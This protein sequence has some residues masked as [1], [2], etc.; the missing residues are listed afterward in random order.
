MIIPVTVSW[1]GLQCVIV[2]SPDHTHLLFWSKSNQQFRRR[3]PLKQLLT[4]HDGRPT[5]NDHNRI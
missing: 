4:T 5:S 3:C 1:V 2:V